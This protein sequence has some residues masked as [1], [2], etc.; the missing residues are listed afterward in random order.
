[1]ETAHEMT[2]TVSGGA[3][4]ST[5]SNP[6]CVV[7]YLATPFPSPKRPT[8]DA[9][10]PRTFPLATVADGD[11]DGDRV[12]ASTPVPLVLDISDGAVPLALDTSDGASES[13][14]HEQPD[15][16]PPHS[17]HQ[18]SPHYP[19]HVKEAYVSLVTSH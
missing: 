14:F 13:S 8:T 9:N 11:T 16:S 15:S 17:D 19:D 3:L 7:E 5:E 6:Y 12:A 10:S 2:Y 1:M 18:N 4:N